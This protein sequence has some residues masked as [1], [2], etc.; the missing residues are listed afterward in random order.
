MF[1][2][3]HVFAAGSFHP[4]EAGG[5]A[6]AAAASESRRGTLL[7]REFKKNRPHIYARRTPRE[8]QADG[9]QAMRLCAGHSA[10]IMIT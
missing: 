1:L 7:K 10:Q 2:L 3:L 8:L 5:Q 4:F 6:K 9:P